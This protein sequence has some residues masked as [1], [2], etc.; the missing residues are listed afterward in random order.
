MMRNVFFLLFSLVFIGV[1]SWLLNS[2]LKVAANGVE[3]TGTVTDIKIK[4]NSDGG[5]SYFPIVQFTLEDGESYTHQLKQSSSSGAYR[6]GDPILLI[7]EKGNKET[8]RI[9]SVFWLYGFPSIFI[10]AGVL[11]IVINGLFRVD[12]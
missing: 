4:S 8:V 7:Y 10:G 2:N 5:D 6:V 12:Y 3:T 11:F 1:G 9:N